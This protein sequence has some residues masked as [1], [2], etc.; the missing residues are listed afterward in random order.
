MKNKA[1][2]WQYECPYSHL[3]KECGHELRGPE[4]YEG[5]YGV[6]C[7]CGFRG[8]VFYLSPEDLKLEKLK[9]ITGYQQEN[10]MKSETKA[11]LIGYLLDHEL[12][13]FYR[14]N[15]F[16][17]LRPVFVDIIGRKPGAGPIAVNR[18]F[19]VEGE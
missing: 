3:E 1:D 12:D 6:W 14:Q 5:M 19:K 4:G 8:P 16:G 9:V 2:Y 7:S 11:I 17:D 18:H 10:E 15:D 13:I